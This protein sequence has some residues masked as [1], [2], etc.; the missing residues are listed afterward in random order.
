MGLIL[1]LLKIFSFL[2]FFI[3]VKTFFRHFSTALF[4]S[5]LFLIIPWQIQSSRFQISQ[6]LILIITSLFFLIVYKNKRLPNFKKLIMIFVFSFLS[7]MLL[8]INNF[9]V[10]NLPFILNQQE[11]AH[12]TLCQNIM[13]PIN[14]TLSRF[15]T[16]KATG[17]LKNLEVNFFESFDLNYYFFVNHPLERVGVKETEKLYSWL[18]PFFILGCVFLNI[19]NNGPIILWVSSVF[20]FS[21]LFSN[22]FSEITILLMIP[23]LLIIG[24]G[25]EKIRNEIKI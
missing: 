3:L 15:Y 4:L 14:P 6:F 24:L 5:I 12:I 19:I 17:I 9:P 23:F 22:R 7:S 21:S 25:V 18:L 2:T 11:I 20:L 16:N 13:N 8:V 10:N 1:I